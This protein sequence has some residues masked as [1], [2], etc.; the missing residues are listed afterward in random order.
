MYGNI[1]D[2]RQKEKNDWMD[3]Q[4]AVSGG[5]ILFASVYDTMYIEVIP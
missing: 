4:C 5:C 2:D 1:I 3:A